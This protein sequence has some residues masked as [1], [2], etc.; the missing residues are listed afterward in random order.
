VAAKLNVVSVRLVEE[1]PMVSDTPIRTPIDAVRLL[2]SDM[3]TLDREVICVINL[4]SDGVP[5]CCNYISVGAVN[6]CMAHPR[7]I[8]KSAILCN[9]TSML[10]IHNH[11]SGN[12]HPSKEDTMIT[13]RM[14]KLGEI[15]GIPLVDHIIVGGSNEAYFSFREKRELEYEHVKLETNY[16]NLSF[17]TS[18]VAEA[19]EIGKEEVSVPKRR[20]GR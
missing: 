16:E 12:L 18:L 9:A 11:P 5:V 15:I 2:G 6:E 13:D 7:E 3:C 17:P 4:R 14:L 20:K 1:Q 8:L 19:D 10:L